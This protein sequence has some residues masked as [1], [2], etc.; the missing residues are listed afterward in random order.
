MDL[1]EESLY[2]EL[3]NMLITDG[4]ESCQYH[5]WCEDNQRRVFSVVFDEDGLRKRLYP[6]HW[7]NAM[8]H[9]G[10]FTSREFDD[11]DNESRNQQIKEAQG[12]NYIVGD[13]VILVPSGDV[14]PD[15]SI[16]GDNPIR[17]IVIPRQPGESM[18]SRYGAIDAAL[19]IDYQSKLEVFNNNSGTGISIRRARQAY[20]LLP[21]IPEG[22]RSCFDQNFLSMLRSWGFDD[23]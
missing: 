22:G 10:R 21:P 2:N 4:I 23:V 11:I 9:A 12:S 16:V 8:I 14:Q 6:N 19:R 3:K 20:Y 18:V 15:L 17:F 7:V 5:L 1:P 13:A